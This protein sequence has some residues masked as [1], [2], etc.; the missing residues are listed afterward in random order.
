MEIRSKQKLSIT[1]VLH[2]HRIKIQRGKP[3]NCPFHQDTTNGTTF[4]SV[5]QTLSI[6]TENVN[7]PVKTI[8]ATNLDEKIAKTI[9]TLTE[10][11]LK[12]FVN[13]SDDSGCYAKTLI[14]NGEFTAEQL[15]EIK[16]SV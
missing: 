5:T 14:G 15:N 2:H 11:D 16:K 7:T 10:V 6:L 3:I 8:K 9:R 4:I 12:T 13:I 1:V